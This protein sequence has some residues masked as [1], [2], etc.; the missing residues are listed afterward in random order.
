MKRFFYLLLLAA[1]FG[2]ASCT[3]EPIVSDTV[4]GGNVGSDVDAALVAKGWVRVRLAEQATPLRVGSFTRGE[5]ASGNP[6]LDELAASLGAT[7]IRKVFPENPRFRERHHKYG[8]HLWYDVKF[9]EDVPVSRAQARFAD[10]PGVE[11]VQPI[12]L[13]QATEGAD[14]PFPSEMNAALP[15][16]YEGNRREMPFNDP[17]LPMQ[18]HYDNDGS[19]PNS[20]EGADIGV[21]EVWKNGTA[22]DPSIIVAV[23]DN[24]VEFSHEDIRDNM[25]VNEAEK[26]GRAGND[27]DG[28]GYDDDVFGYDFDKKKGSI[29]PG[30]HGTHVAGTVAAV[31]NNGIG[32]CGVAGG[33]GNADGARIMSCVVYDETGYGFPPPDAYIYAADNGA[34]ISQNSWNYPDPPAGPSTLP[35]DMAVA[36]GYFIDNA[37]I[38]PDG[39]QTGPMKGGI[40]LFAAGN[41]FSPRLGMPSDDPR[42][43]AVT[44]MLPN[45]AKAMYSNHSPQAAIFAPGGAGSDDVEFGQEGKVYSLGLDNTY[46]YKNGTSMACP[47]V[48]GIAALMVARYGVGHE[49]FTNEDLKALLLKS[50]RNVDSYQETAAIANNLG[51]GLIDVSLM[52]L[53]NPGVAPE[54]PE[55][56]TV[57]EATKER[58]LTVTVAG[59]PADGNGMGISKIRMKYA[60]EGTAD[61]SAD[62][63]EEVFPCHLSVGESMDYECSGLK[64]VTTYVFRASAIDRFGNESSYVSGSGTTMEHINRPPSI[65]KP[66]SRID[67]PKGSGT[68]D[69][70]FIASLELTDYFSDPDFPYDELFFSVVSKDSEI[71]KATVEGSVLTIE[72]LKKG[73]TYVSIEV[74]DRAGETI[75]K[76]M[77]VRVLKDREIAPPPPPVVEQVELQEGILNIFPNPAPDE[78][79][80]GV[81]GAEGLKVDIDIYDAAARKVVSA[82][83]LGFGAEGTEYAGAVKYD[84]S[85]LSPGSYTVSATL[86]DGR[87]F[88][89]SFLKR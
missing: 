73:E 81:K 44:A 2:A 50:Y 23:M 33:T 4:P 78:V 29:K 18:W 89:S 22:G 17:L 32:V 61:G 56:V 64:D 83:G 84:V 86:S 77:A 74:K 11:Y 8:L 10:I 52:E 88:K 79:Y 24:G 43:L 5:V 31:N 63:L 47:H 1:A 75:S 12:Y 87:R 59:I 65:I 25:W 58:K 70:D 66:L 51:A 55:A 6:Q 67:L 37:G 13:I 3:R 72:G 27:D 19:L 41:G 35:Q 85:R 20:V 34:V 42:V 48:S 26:N 16:S 62:W 28:N 38:G 57:A 21:F 45:Y 54:A 53:E 30:D 49:G 69:A 40:I 46:A 60:P 7:E 76:N 39:E 68:Q 82:S 80:L 15:A 14:Y 36:L 9:D 71:V